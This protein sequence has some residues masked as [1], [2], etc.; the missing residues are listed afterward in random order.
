[1]TRPPIK[2]TDSNTAAIK[3]A[4]Y[5]ITIV[6]LVSLGMWTT[7]SAYYYLTI[8]QELVDGEGWSVLIKELYSNI[9]LNFGHSIS[10]GL[11]AS[12]GWALLILT[13]VALLFLMC[14]H[15]IKNLGKAKALNPLWMISGI[16]LIIA[17]RYFVIGYTLKGV[18]ALVLSAVPT[19]IKILS[20]KSSELKADQYC[21]EQEKIERVQ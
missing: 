12:L 8:G 20:G 9:Y 16:F 11:T 17:G 18:S 6:N 7:F 10:K 21:T 3:S 1:M 2:N 19:I 5:R 4:S 14:T 15:L 13:P